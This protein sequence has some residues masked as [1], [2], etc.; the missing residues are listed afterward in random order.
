MCVRVCGW[1]WRAAASVRRLPPLVSALEVEELRRGL[2]DAAAGT[3][4]VLQA[5]DCAER[6][7]DCCADKI[8]EKVLLLHQMATMLSWGCRQPVV[9]IGRIAGQFSKPRSSATEVVDGVSYPSFRGDN[10]NGFD[11]YSREHDP[12]RLVEGYFHSAATLNHLRSVAEHGIPRL[13]TRDAWQLSA[14]TAH[15]HR[16]RYMKA[17]DAVLESLEFAGVAGVVC[18]DQVCAG[19]AISPGSRVHLRGDAGS[20]RT[21]GRLPPLY[22]SHEGLTL[23]YEEAMTR[24]VSPGVYYNLGAHFLWIGTF[25]WV[26]SACVCLQTGRSTRTGP[27]V[28]WLCVVCCVCYVCGSSQ[29]GE[30]AAGSGR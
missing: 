15:S 1:L 13:V 23:G 28:G 21:A 20:Q 29:R 12:A 9:R 27:A 26:R 30:R 8:D 25:G 17:V 4:F 19:P 6:F 2:A 16:H 22:T 5:G 18:A 10:I 24:E 14:A 3:R 7:I 11:R